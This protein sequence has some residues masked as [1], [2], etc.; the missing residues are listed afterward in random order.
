MS[1]KFGEKSQSILETVKPELQAVVI[2]AL[3]ISRI[4]FSV[5]SGLRTEYEQAAL[6]AIGKSQAMKSRHLTGDAVDLYPWR[7][8]ATDH[9]QEAYFLLARAMFRA[10]QELGVKL[11]WGGFWQGF[12]DNPHWELV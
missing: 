8:G 3:E 9:S 6:V 5:V 7:N 4:D 2:R 10:S 1:F 12:T 11:D